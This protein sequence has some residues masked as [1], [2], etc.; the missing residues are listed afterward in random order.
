M[1]AL[2]RFV[3]A[4]GK[5]D[6]LIRH[7]VPV[8]GPCVICGRETSYT[9]YHGP[10]TV[11]VCH[12]HEGMYNDGNQ[13]SPDCKATLTEIRCEYVN[14]KDHLPNAGG[15]IPPASGGNLDRIVGEDSSC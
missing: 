11:H 8:L 4:G 12:P 6:D 15:Q 13:A 9:L 5:I 14:W 2:N 1:G 10:D 3:K 7:A